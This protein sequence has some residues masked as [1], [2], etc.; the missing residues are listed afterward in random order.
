MSDAPAPP[1]A[2]SPLVEGLNPEQAAAVLHDGGPLLIVAGAGSG[3]T[4]VLTHRIAHLIKARGVN[5][6]GVLAITFTNKAADEMK[7][8]VG[9]LVGD[10][11]VGVERNDDG[12]PKRRRWGG[13]WVSTF[14]A[15][16]ARLLRAEAHRMGYD[17]SFTIYDAGDSTRLDGL[18]IKDLNIDPKRITPRG[19]ANAISKAKNELV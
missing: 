9:R 15:A 1:A 11:L 5:P 7:D 18:C 12:T 3:K 19:A 16:C 6:Y 4:R 14:H 8:R 13:R 10:R 17:K 2:D